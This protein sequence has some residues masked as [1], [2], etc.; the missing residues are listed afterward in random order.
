MHDPD[1]WEAK[2]RLLKTRLTE[3]Q[4]SEAELRKLASAVQYSPISVMI[5]D[6]LGIIEYVNPKFCQVTGYTPEE[7][8][9][10]TPR[11]LKGDDLSDE[12]Y[13]DMWQ[14]ILSKREWHGEFHNRNKD[15][16]LVWELASISPVCDESGEI[17][18]F[19]GVKEDISELKRLQ[20]ELGQLA[21][22]DKLTGLPNRALLYDRL[23]QA[24][25]QAKRKR[26]RFA[27]LYADLDGFKA[28]NDR[29]GHQ[30]GDELLQ[31]AARR[32]VSC[33]R[34]SDTVA[35]MGGDEFVI[36]L[37]DLKHWEESSIVARKLLEAIG[38]PFSVGEI[39]CRIGISIG[40]SIYPDN[41]E[42]VQKLI[43]CADF[44]LYEVKQ[45]G[46]NNYRYS[47]KGV[48]QRDAGEKV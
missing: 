6:P 31:A 5:T 33:V 26:S 22:S 27:L 24:M 17:T 20:K 15:G 48:Q 11:I 3:L 10:Q 1:G 43:S 37:S 41:A 25:V 2:N 18:H 40:I 45:S 13:R 9:G 29:H 42:D 7:V 34:E 35:R 4:R 32:L 23:E 19:V 8:I 36:L 44:A 12:V 46:K 28:V 21:H 16:S 47:S 39:V 30:T 38:A 14:T